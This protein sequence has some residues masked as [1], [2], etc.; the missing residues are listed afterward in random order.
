VKF[1]DPITIAVAAAL[2]IPPL[3]ALY[4][5]KLKRA[6]RIVPSTLLWK[7]AIEDLRVNAP[8]QRLR[9]SLLLLL[10][11]LVLALAALALGKPMF[12]AAQT[13][14]GTLILLIDQSASMSVMEKGGATRLDQAKEQAKNVVDAM[15]DDARAMVI[16]FSDRGNVV[17]SFDTDKQAI[18]R[19]IDSIEQTQSTTS[20]TEAISLAE[21]YAQNLIIGGDAPGA[22]VGA[23]VSAAPSA[24]VFLFSDG[25]IEDSE[26][27][28]F[29][30]IDPSLMRITTIGERSDNVGIVH[31]AARRNYERPNFL[32]VTAGVRN[33]GSQPVTV[34][35]TLYVDGRSVDEKTLQLSPATR[36]AGETANPEANQEA[37]SVDTGAQI[38][39]F[40]QLECGGGGVVE[41]VLKVDDAL[42]ADDRA[43]SV[44]DPPRQLR[45]L[46]VS[47][48]FWFLENVLDTLDAELVKMSGAQYENTN[49]NQIAAEKR[50]LFDV[51]I[52]DRHTTA[53]L[54]QGNYFFWGAVPRIEGVALGEPIRNEILFDWDETHPVLRYIAVDAVD[55]AEW[56]ALKLPPEAKSIIDGESS[57]VLAYLTRDASQYLISA[58]SLVVRDDKGATRFNTDW[59]TK[60]DFVIFMQN[61]VQFL[62]SN[63]SLIGK[64]SIVPGEAVTLMAQAGEESVTITRPDG[65]SDE[66][67]AGQQQS[68]HYGRTRQ[69]GIYRVEPAAPGQDAFAVNLFNAVESNIAPV[70]TLTVGAE[71]AKPQTASVE[72]NKPAWRYFL[73]AL[74]GLLLLEWVVYNR[75]VMV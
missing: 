17:G 10:Q 40:D 15:S 18:R 27:T 29:R 4:F 7:K 48:D 51:V 46:L 20:L 26:Q 5:L 66:V 69:V 9:K 39:V 59:P 64:R 45:V 49:E 72:V 65:T 34:D 35:A 50:S 36:P 55:V 54:P 22:D 41:V 24:S 67:S 11:L 53:R 14:E 47:P 52:F 38:A 70:G 30:H 60:L 2:T 8:F 58:F 68:I 28:P 57:P 1:L 23:P 56:F 73:L 6:V 33:Y 21:A 12:Q 61:A 43:W 63:Q 74:L 32:E 13:H 42:A 31:M 19:K 37:D 44:I 3:V 25:R 16:A 75:R 71:G 62:A